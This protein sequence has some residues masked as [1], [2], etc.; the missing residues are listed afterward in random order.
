[1]ELQC[2]DKLQ[3]TEMKCGTDAA[4][5]I[6]RYQHKQRKTTET[7]KRIHWRYIFSHLITESD[8][9]NNQSRQITQH[10]TLHSK[11]MWHF[12]CTHSG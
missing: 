9:S 10:C 8:S 1:M 11:Q 6:T 12:Q 3:I 5:D 2:E 4:S 7:N